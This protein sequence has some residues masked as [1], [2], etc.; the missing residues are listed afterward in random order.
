MARNVPGLSRAG[1]LLGE[2][3]KPRGSAVQSTDLCSISHNLAAQGG[4]HEIIQGGFWDIGN[5]CRPQRGSDTFSA[6]SRRS[7]L[8]EHGTRFDDAYSRTADIH[9]TT[10]SAVPRLHMNKI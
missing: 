6:L 4:M 10:R 1:N 8:R 3:G 2:G 9:P 7:R 5:T